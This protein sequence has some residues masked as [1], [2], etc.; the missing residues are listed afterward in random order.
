MGKKQ[1]TTRGGARFAVLAVAFGGACF[2]LGFVAAL[3]PRVGA[4][5]GP[6]AEQEM[7]R[8]AAAPSIERR[9]KRRKVERPY[10]VRPAESCPATDSSAEREYRTQQSRELVGLLRYKISA[11][12]A[13]S[14]VD[15]PEGVMN[16]LAP[17]LMGW[18]DALVRTAP[19][20]V[21]ELAAEFEASMCNPDTNPSEV[22][23]LSR[24]IGQMPELGNERG[25]DCIFE[26]GTED[27]VLWTTLDAWR[28]SAMPK[29]PALIKL[30]QR[31]RDERTQRR[32]VKVSDEHPP[33]LAEVV[34][35]ASVLKPLQQRP[36]EEESRTEIPATGESS[37]APVAEV[38]NP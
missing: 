37:Q 2:G 11:T 32:L 14:P 4:G 16:G 26:R 22:M 36:D 27:M 20:M 35:L 34:D 33:E 15:G 29:S 23:V 21:D 25:F 7:E 18:T 31:A 24:V 17:W 38:V 6:A 13:T 28:A 1:A 30:E 12:E 3:P 10:L 9:Q 19:D 8:V 5:S